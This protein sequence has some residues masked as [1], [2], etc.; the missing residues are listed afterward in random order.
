MGQVEVL[1]TLDGNGWM[2]KKQI[3]KYLDGVCS[4]QSIS[5]CLTKLVI[6][7]V[8]LVKKCPTLKRGYLYKIRDDLVKK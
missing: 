1:N 8:V 7:K 6:N 4:G 2:T 5:G 3:A